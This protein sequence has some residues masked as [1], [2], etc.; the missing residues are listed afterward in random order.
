MEQYLI[1]VV[2]I[3]LFVLASAVKIVQEYERG[4]IFRLEQSSGA[5]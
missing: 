1:P 5:G 3:V 4:V 2:I